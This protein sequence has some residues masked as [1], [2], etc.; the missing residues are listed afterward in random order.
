MGK[1]ARHAA[2]GNRWMIFLVTGPTVL[3]KAAYTA[4]AKTVT[5]RRG[6]LRTIFLS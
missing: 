5:A 4:A 3:R 2:N 6:R 1:S